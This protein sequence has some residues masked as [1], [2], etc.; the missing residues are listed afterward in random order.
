MQSLL[1]GAPCVAALALT[2]VW[3][4]RRKADFGSYFAAHRSIGFSVA[5]VSFPVCWTW[6]NTLIIG[7]QKAFQNGLATVAWFSVLNA[8]A[9][10]VYALCDTQLR[11]VAKAHVPTLTGYMQERF[12]MPMVWVYS[13]GIL[14]VSAYAVVG[15]LIGAL[16]L[17][18]YATGWDREML[19]VLLAGMMFIIAYPRGIE[20]SFSADM[21]KACTIGL[22]LMLAIFVIVE[23]RGSQ[24]PLPGSGLTDLLDPGLLRNFVIPLA[25][26]WIAGGAVDHQLYQ[27]GRSLSASARTAPWHGILPFGILVFVISSVGF[28]APKNTMQGLDPQL[29][30][31]VAIEFWVPRAGQAFIVMVAAALLATGASALNA[32]ASTWAVDIVRPMNPKLSPLTVSRIATAI[33]ALGSA[34]LALSGITLVQMVLFIGSFRG[35]LLFPTLYGLFVGKRVEPSPLFAGAIASAMCIGPIVAYASGDNLWGGVAALGLSGLACALELRR[36]A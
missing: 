12:G 5:V 11:K 36:N 6:A 20:S 27:R 28:F 22:V 16:V 18:N 31:F 3:F 34:W 26:S 29:A 25:I 30:G 1:L 21:V 33:I 7:P 17:L 35:A 10:A 13:I 32:S 19:V 2:V 4:G 24:G 9:L 15:Q 14:G 8:L 23:G